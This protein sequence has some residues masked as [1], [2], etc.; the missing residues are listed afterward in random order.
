MKRLHFTS[1]ETVE[2]FK[3]VYADAGTHD[4]VMQRDF[5]RPPYLRFRALVQSDAR[6]PMRELEGLR[7]QCISYS[8]CQLRIC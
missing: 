3:F 2:K 5:N 7:P 8:G 6:N 4:S 1:L